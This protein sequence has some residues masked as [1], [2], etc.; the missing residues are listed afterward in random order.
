[1]NLLSDS[2]EFCPFCNVNLQGDP[3]PKKWQETYGA[4]H[5]TRKI[6]IMCME[7][8]RIVKWQCPD[9]KKEWDRL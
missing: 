8:D 6:G 4:T 3:I 1:M 5:F 9:C 7:S 2:K